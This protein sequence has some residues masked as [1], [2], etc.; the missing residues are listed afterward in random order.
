MIAGDNLPD[1]E[2]HEEDGDIIRVSRRRLVEDDVPMPRFD[3]ATIDAAREAA[4]GWDVYALEAEWR[5]FWVASGRQKLRAPDKAFLGWLRGVK[6][7]HIVP[8]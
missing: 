4:P 2:L 8:E 1:Y 3:A 5:A 6:P 7:A